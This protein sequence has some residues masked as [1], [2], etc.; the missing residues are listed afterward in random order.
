MVD[1]APPCI[2]ELGAGVPLDDQPVCRSC[3]QYFAI[4]D[5]LDR[6]QDLRFHVHTL[7]DELWARGFPVVAWAL[8]KVWVVKLAKRGMRHD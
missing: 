5:P 6:K 3:E 4:F 2:R 8:E 1:G 7:S